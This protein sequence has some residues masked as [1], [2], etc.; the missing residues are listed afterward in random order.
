[1]EVTQQEDGRV[2]I[3]IPDLIL[4]PLPH[5]S[6]K[7]I[8]SFIIKDTSKAQ[9]GENTLTQGHTANHKWGS[10][11]KAGR[12]GRGPVLNDLTGSHSLSLST[13]CQVTPPMTEVLVIV[14]SGGAQRGLGN[15]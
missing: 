15:R 11:S 10:D 4:C 1:M 14:G 3:K 12:Q 6:M 13:R 7:D 9:R 8:P 2:R 5:S